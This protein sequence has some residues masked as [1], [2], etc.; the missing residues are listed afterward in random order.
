MVFQFKV[1]EK[2][3]MISMLQYII[4]DVG[5]QHSVSRHIRVF[6]EQMYTHTLVFNLNPGTT[7]CFT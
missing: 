1:P 4:M 3:S 5:R 6:L 2:A 7:I